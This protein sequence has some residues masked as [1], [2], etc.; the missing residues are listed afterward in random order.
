M[1]TIVWSLRLTLAPKKDEK[2]A[3]YRVALD[4]WTVRRQPIEH[5]S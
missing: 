1:A 5:D 3:A 2:M 4:A